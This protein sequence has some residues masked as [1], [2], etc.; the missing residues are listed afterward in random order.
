MT[1][2]FA[3]YEV[4][5]KGRCT[6]C[7][8]APHMKCQKKIKDQRAERERLRIKEIVDRAEQHSKER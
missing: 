4:P 5:K 1:I 2:C 8:A 7:G 6:I 3:G